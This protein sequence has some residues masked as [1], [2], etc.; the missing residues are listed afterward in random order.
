MQ[1]CNKARPFEALLIILQFIKLFMILNK[2]EREQKTNFP[3]FNKYFINPILTL[4]FL[5]LNISPYKIDNKIKYS[6][7]I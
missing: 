7:E 4:F 6:Y 1:N 5:S 2:I 3:I